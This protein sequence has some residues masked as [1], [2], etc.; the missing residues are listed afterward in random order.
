MK[1]AVIPAA[2]KG[3]RLGR[4]GA[5]LPKALV[6]I[7]GRPAID[8]I[9]DM[10]RHV[11]VERVLMIVGY[12]KEQLISYIDDGSDFGLRVAHVT[13]PEA[14]G[15]A[16]A[17]LEAEP[18]VT[19]DFLCLLGDTLLFPQDSLKALAELHTSRHAAATLLVK[20]MDDVTSFGVVEPDGE[21]VKGVVEKPKAGEEKSKLAIVGCY[22]FSP[23]IFEAA[24]KTAPN[25][26]T[27]E[28]ELT[29]AVQHLIESG[30]LVLH[31]RFE[32]TYIDTGKMEQ[33]HSADRM[34]RGAST[35][36]GKS[37]KI[38]LDSIPSP[39][40][41]TVTPLFSGPTLESALTVLKEKQ[42]T[43]G[44]KHADAEEIYIFLEGHGQMQA[45][46]ETYEV[47]P[48]DVVI[49]APGD[50]HK[51]TNTGRAPISFVAVYPSSPIR[52]Y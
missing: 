40:E 49:I 27:G 12:K 37:C 7:A 6:P 29:D 5:A 13:Q 34:L 45:G 41:K 38:E 28:I 22:A 48:G 19:D 26:A 39:S 9:F 23:K 2:G 16:H 25:P 8:H 52:E 35:F 24:R 1:I 42:S 31:V 47:E 17:L 21:K 11:G 30:E 33:I 3:T 51:V 4:V 10:L 18:F 20:K 15:I 50:F 36:N 46:S 44:H 32:G 14:K 43:S